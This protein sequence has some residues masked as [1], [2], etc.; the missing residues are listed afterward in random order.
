MIGSCVTRDV[1]KLPCFTQGDRQSVFVLART[2]LASLFTPPLAAFAPPAEPPAGL[3]PFEIR[4][5]GHDLLKTGP[6]ALAAHRPTHLVLDLIDERFDLL[7]RG[8][9]VVTR[10]W[11]TSLLGLEERELAG[12]ALV[13]RQSG[14]ARE[15]WRRGLARFADFLKAEL[16]ATKVILHDARCAT[17]RRDEDGRISPLGPDWEFWPGAASG[18]SALNALLAD[19]AAEILAALPQ[20][21]VVKAPEALTLATEAH[22]WGLA[23]FHYVDDYYQAVW[24]QLQR[25]GCAPSA[26]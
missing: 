8:D 25:L 22:R 6:A 3:S 10:S 16:P 24:A 9:T 18:V 17:A 12:F 15:L 20:A 2:S 4:M 5:V 7:R 13:P 21:A 11:E 14:E 23:P 1:W 19:Y 26:A